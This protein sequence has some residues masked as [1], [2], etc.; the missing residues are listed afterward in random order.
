MDP[1]VLRG[2]GLRKRHLL[3]LETTNQR[4]N[5]ETQQ[6][7]DDSREYRAAARRPEGKAQRKQSPKRRN[8]RPDVY[9]E[10]TSSAPSSSSRSGSDQ[11]PPSE[12]SRRSRRAGY[13]PGDTSTVSSRTWSSNTSSA[14]DGTQYF[15]ICRPTRPRPR[16]QPTTPPPTYGS[17][18]RDTGHGVSVEHGMWPDV[19]VSPNVHI[20]NNSD[21]NVGSPSSEM[22]SSMSRDHPQGKARD[23]DSTLGLPTEVEPIAPLRTGSKSGRKGRHGAAFGPSGLFTQED[24][25]WRRRQEEEEGKGGRSDDSSD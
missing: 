13:I 8:K 20:A 18:V 3:A 11:Y 7:I 5:H 12:T 2:I 6:C 15:E 4:I 10:G 9:F 21:G 16:R 23:K 24:L 14:S 25:E 1:E 17:R 22:D 19:L